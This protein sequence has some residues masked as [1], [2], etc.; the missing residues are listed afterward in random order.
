MQAKVQ[1]WLRAGSIG[2]LAAASVFLWGCN[3]GDDNNGVIY[4]G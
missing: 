2:L 4:R 3:G 1:Q